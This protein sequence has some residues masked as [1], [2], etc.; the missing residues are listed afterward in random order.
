MFA[1]CKGKKGG[2]RGK[3]H[4][5]KYD[6]AR[7]MTRQCPGITL[8]ATSASAERAPNRVLQGSLAYLPGNSMAGDFVVSK[9]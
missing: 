2:T 1:M 8:Q 4:P 6:R 3:H 7:S 5:T 9:H